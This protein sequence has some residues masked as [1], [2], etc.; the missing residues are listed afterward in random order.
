[1]RKLTWLML[2]CMQDLTKLMVAKL[3]QNELFHARTLE[4]QRLVLLLRN[5][6]WVVSK[7][8][9]L[10]KT[11]A[12]ISINLAMLRKLALSSI[13][14]RARNEA[15]VLWSMMTMMLLTNASC[16]KTTQSVGKRWM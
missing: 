15:L 5:F 8:H 11:S 2:P 3:N 4:G 1:M 12:I 10:R 16:T 13:K 6:L 14:I 9:T 7:M